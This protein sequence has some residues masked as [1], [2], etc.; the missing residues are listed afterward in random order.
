MKH[1]FNHKFEECWLCGIARKDSFDKELFECHGAGWAYQPPK[2]KKSWPK[3]Q[4]FI[5]KPIEK[6]S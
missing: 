3:R 5:R 1:T 6:E 4:K 2:A